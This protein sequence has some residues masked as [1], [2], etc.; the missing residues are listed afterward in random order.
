MPARNPR[1]ALAAL[2]LALLLP[3]CGGGEEAAGGAAG[4]EPAATSSPAADSGLDASVTVDTQAT[5][6]DTAALR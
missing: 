4:D 5:P 2:A 3:A 1:L 6:G